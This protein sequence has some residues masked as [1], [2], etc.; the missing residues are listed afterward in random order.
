MASYL[1]TIAVGFRRHKSKPLIVA[2]LGVAL[3]LAIVSGARLGMYLE[4]VLRK[5]S[6]LRPGNEAE[7]LKGNES[8]TSHLCTP[9]PEHCNVFRTKQLHPCNG[10]MYACSL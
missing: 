6:R 2:G 9:I 5:A 10:P 4:R 7:Y 8:A 1:H 3:V